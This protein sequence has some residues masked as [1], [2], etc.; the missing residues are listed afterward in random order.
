MAKSTTSDWWR[1]ERAARERGFAVIAGIDEAGRGPLAGPVVAACVI[2]PFEVDIPEVRDSKTL[3][4]M[5]R[6]RAYGRIQDAALGIGVG[7]GDVEL[8]DRINI[9][10]ATHEAMRDALAAMATTAEFV[11][12]DG[13]PV[14]PFPIPHSAIVKGDGRSASIAAASIIAKVTRDRM[15][16]QLDSEFPQYG[17][18][19]H[20]GYATA[21]HHARLRA[22]GPCPIHRRAFLPEPESLAQAAL[23]FDPE[24]HHVGRAGEVVVAAH[25]ER[26]GWRV[27]ETR[28]HCRGGEIDIVAIE[29]ETLVFVEVKSTRR[30]SGPDATEAVNRRKRRRIATAATA[31]VAARGLGDCRCRF[32]VAEV[33]MRPDGCASVELQTAPFMSDE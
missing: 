2:L 32:D 3:S 18:A 11:L 23:P 17:F 22:H 27:L 31:Y 30:K 1:E 9:L 14:Q 20:K 16:V 26:L 15:M 12:I 8:I 13:L 28:F 24:I 4:P 7:I 29:S 21:E 5:Q 33:R 6:D 10:R 25:L 19:V